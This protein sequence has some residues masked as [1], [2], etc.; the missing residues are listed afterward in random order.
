MVTESALCKTFMNQTASISHYSTSSPPHLYGSITVPCPFQGNFLYVHIL[1]RKGNIISC[2]QLSPNH[3]CK[4]S[5][6][7]SCCMGALLVCASSTSFTIWLQTCISRFF[8]VKK[9]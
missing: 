8:T 5:S 7:P 3:V 9:G 1:K 2:K 6:L 4:K